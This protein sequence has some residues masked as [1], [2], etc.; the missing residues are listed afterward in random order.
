MDF[1]PIIGGLTAFIVFVGLSTPI[2]VIGIIYFYKKRLEHKQILAAIEKGTPL[3]EL[4][5]PKPRGPIWIKY[6]TGGIAWII[7][8]VG[9]IWW[10]G[11]T[12]DHIW[13]PLILFAIGVAWLIRGLLYKKYQPSVEPS[14]KNGLAVNKSS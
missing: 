4:R 9:L 3:S 14:D 8:A 1:D 5:P 11:Y 2:I 6:L 10:L 13:A 12:S 7:I